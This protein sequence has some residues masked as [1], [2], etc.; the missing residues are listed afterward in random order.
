MDLRLLLLLSLTLALTACVYNNEEELYP[1]PPE[2]CDTLA[3]SY[4]A[5]IIPLFTIHEC[6]AC[7][8]GATPNGNVGM[9]SYE[10]VKVLADNGMLYGTIAHLPGFSPMPKDEPQ[11]LDCEI[12][13]IKAWIDQGALNN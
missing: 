2:A 10:K 6:I 11:L 4:Q 12:R 3:V 9:D 13:Q 8:Q 7:H 1:I 5:T